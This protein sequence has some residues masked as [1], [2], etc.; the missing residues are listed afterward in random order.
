MTD[1]DCELC[2]GE[3][4]TEYQNFKGDYIAEVCECSFSDLDDYDIWKDGYIDESFDD[5]IKRNG[6]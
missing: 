5:M 3:G 2:G 4:Y 1:I 6:L